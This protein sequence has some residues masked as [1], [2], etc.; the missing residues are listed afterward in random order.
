MLQRLPTDHHTESNLETLIEAVLE[1]VPRIR[2]LQLDHAGPLYH[3]LLQTARYDGSFY[4][5]TSAAVLLADLAIPRDWF[6]DERDWADANK[7]AKLKICDPAC[8]T[9][10]LL[11]A[12]ARSIQERYLSA[13]GIENDLEVLH[14]TLIEDV[15][16]G[17]DINRH[18]I[19]LAACMLT[20]TAPKIDYNKMN[21]YNM[22]HGVNTEGEVRAGSLDLLVDDASYIPG[23]AP[24]TTQFRTAA[25]GYRDEA[26]DLTE[27]CDLV[28]M[29]PP[30]TRNDIRNRSLPLA[31]R[32]LVQQ[33]E[34]NLAQNTSD[35][36]H[37]QTI[38]QSTIGTFFTPIADLLLNTTGS[39][40]LVKPYTVCTNASGKHERN[41]L[42]SP[43]RFHLELVV[44][45]HDNRRIYFSENTDIHESLIIARRP[46]PESEK[47]PTA[48]VSLAENPASASEAHYLAQAIRSALDGD[49]SQLANYGTIT[50]RSLEQL[51]DKPWNAACFYDQTL[52]DAYDTLLQNA[53]LTLTSAIAT[54]QPGGQRVRDAFTKARQRQNPDMRALWSHKSNRQKAMRT[55]PDVFLVSKPEMHDYAGKL[56]KMRSSLL[57]VNRMW[58][59]L[60]RT[61]AVFSDTPILG[62]AFV[63]VTPNG[64]NND[65]L[66][67]A[68]CVWFNSTPGII[69]F[70]NIRQKKLSY[71]HFSL[72]GLRSL[73]IP[74]P[75]ECDIDRLVVAYNHFANETLLAL[76]QMNEDPVRSALDDA[77]LE[78]VP[79]LSN[80]DVVQWRNSIPLEPSVNNKKMPFQL[81]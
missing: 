4:T 12:A 31:E 73:P 6:T 42:T 47:K 54:V 19:H 52:A 33:H 43:D 78:A 77:V 41:L 66:C 44:T 28:I 14:L 57:L 68:W 25:E 60:T 32:K 17:L 61:A 2:G 81:S 79:G 18:A 15:L 50:W 20:L 5:S 40:A 64:E 16:Y 76:P 59:N 30:F 74:N 35:A 22:Q 80:M 75:D 26:P 51:R 46:T 55:T 13:G 23:L 67:K 53:A 70:L 1:C 48:F 56:W 11:M 69:A 27:L 65:A 39:L 34:I 63:P 71:P 10:T 49:T 3:G 37:R 45:S 24:D 38:D 21:L 9:G 8:G 58:L 29:N 62:S 7:L 72:D 36:T